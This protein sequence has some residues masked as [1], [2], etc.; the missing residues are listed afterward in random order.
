MRAQQE[1]DR[2]VR[3]Q[4]DQGDDD[5]RHPGHLGGVPEPLE[6]LV[7]DE[8]GHAQQQYRVGHRGEH[9]GAMPAVGAR[10]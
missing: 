1:H 4:S 8:R 9:L 2:G 3:G 10:R 5:E 7:Q 6:R